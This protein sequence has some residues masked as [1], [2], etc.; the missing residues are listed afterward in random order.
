MNLKV[1]VCVCGPSL[2]CAWLFMTPWTTARFLCPWD[3]PGKNTG[4]GWDFLLQ[5][6]F[7]NQESN[8]CLLCLLHWQAVSLL[9]WH[10]GSSN[11]EDIILSEISQHKRTNTVWCHLYEV[12]SIV[13]FINMESRRVVTREQ[14][15]GRIRRC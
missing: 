4:V 14:G 2:G 1:S 13:E 8:L 3:F 5:R 15:E 11:L 12:S 6:I 10:L 7:P 9:L